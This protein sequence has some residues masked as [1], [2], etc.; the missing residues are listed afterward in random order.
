M[1]SAGGFRRLLIVRAGSEAWLNAADC[2]SAGLNGPRRFKSFPAHQ[3]GWR[4]ASGRLNPLTPLPR[5]E[6]LMTQAV[7]EQKASSEMKIPVR[8]LF[9][10]HPY[11]LSPQWGEGKED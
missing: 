3:E 11:P 1:A 5:G 10:P 7:R 4:G 2:R 9:P 8:G 6:A